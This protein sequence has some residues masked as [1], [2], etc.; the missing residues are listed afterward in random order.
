MKKVLTILSMLVILMA[1]S[2]SAEKPTECTSIKDGVLNTTEGMTIPLGYIKE[3]PRAGYNYQAMIFN[4]DYAGDKLVMNWNDAWLSNKDCDGDGKLDRHLGFSSYIGSGAWLTNAFSGS[5]EVD[6]K[7]CHW[8]EF[9]KIVA[10]PTDAY[11]IDGYWYTA[12]G[13]LIGQVIW[14]EFAI[15]LDVW[16]DQCANLSGVYAKGTPGFG[17]Y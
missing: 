5:Y 16:N 4:G 1:I 11:L 12:D 6:G 8:T 14:G 9:I 10:V 3:G 13:E 15:T 7:T 2:V 17:L